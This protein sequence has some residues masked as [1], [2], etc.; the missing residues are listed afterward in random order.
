MENQQHGPSH[1]ARSMELLSRIFWWVELPQLRSGGLLDTLLSVAAAAKGGGHPS[2]T[3][4]DGNT[5]TVTPAVGV[6]GR[7]VPVNHVY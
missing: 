6:A 3:H 1:A 7:C 2:V 4:V 5:H